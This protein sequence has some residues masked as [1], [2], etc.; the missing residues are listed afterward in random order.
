MARSDFH[1]ALTNALDLA[2][3]PEVPQEY[4]IE[5]VVDQCIALLERAGWRFTRTRPAGT[6]PGPRPPQPA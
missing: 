6:P 4:D 5:A 2:M 1:V 3:P